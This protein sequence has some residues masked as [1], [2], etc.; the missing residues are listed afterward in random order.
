M[1][2]LVARRGPPYHASVSED[3][4][5]SALRARLEGRARSEVDASRVVS[6]LEVIHRLKAQIKAKDRIISDRTAELVA[7]RDYLDKVFAALSLPVLVIDVTGRVESSNAAAQELL[8]LSA[9]EL[10]GRAAS[11]LWATPEQAAQFAGARLAE[12][13][14]RGGVQ[15]TDLLLRT[16]TGRQVPV[17]WSATVLRTEGHPTALVGVARDVR[18]ERRLEE[19]KLRTV[20]ALAAS[21]AHEIRNPLGAVVNSVGLL[22]RDSKLE[23]E[24][25]T[26]LEIV[27]EETQRIAGIV[28]QFLDFARPVEPQLE[29]GDLGAL[30]REVVA[31]AEQ[32][33]AVQDGGKRLLLYVDAALP[34]IPFDG[35]QIKQVLWNLINNGLDAATSLVAVRARPAA[36]GDGAEVRVADDGPGMPP[37]VLARATEPFRTTKAKGSGLG[38]A[39]CKRIVE[40]HGGTLRLASAAGA[41]TTVSFNLPSTRLEA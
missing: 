41:G 38:L 27:A 1:Q 34:A 39:I 25:L 5:T 19:E 35:D 28:T 2:S 13:F 3:T 11:S 9:H 10:E 16:R 4:G 31:L 40:A 22:R 15:S 36:G 14:S 23:G 30:L 33:E 24:D 17:A 7:T 12:V 29:A 18:V 21:V 20:Q 8:E 37:E 32:H 6:I 26:L